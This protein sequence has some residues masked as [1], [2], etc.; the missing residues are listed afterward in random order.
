MNPVPDRRRLRAGRLASVSQPTSTTTTRAARETSGRSRENRRAFD[1]LG[2]PAADARR[3]VPAGSST[4]I[5]GADVSFPVL[6]APWAYQ[7]LAHPDGERATARARGEG[8]H[9]HGRLLDGGGRSSRRSRARA[10]RSSGGSSTCSR[11]AGGAPRCS[12]GCTRR[13]TRRSASRWT[14]RSAGSV[15]ATRGAASTCRSARQGRPR[16]RAQHLLGRPRRWI[17]E[18][19][20][21]PLLVKGIMTAEDARIAVDQ[22]AD[23]I[24]VS[25]HGGRQLDRGRRRGHGVARGGGGR[26][27][28]DPGPGGRRV[29]PGDRR[30]QGARPRRR[31]RPGGPAGL[32]GPR[33]RGR[34]RRR[35]GA[36]DPADR[37]REHDGARRGARDRGHQG[38]V[39]RSTLTAVSPGLGRIEAVP[40]IDLHTHSNRS[41]GTF[42]PA[43]VVRTAAEMGLDVVALDG[44]RHDRRAGRGARD[45]ASS[46]ASRSSPVSSSRRSSS[47]RASTS[48]ATGS[49]SRTRPSRRELHACGDDRFRRG[50]LIVEKLQDL[51]FDISFERVLADRG[52]GEYRPPARGAGDGRG[53]DRRGPRRRPSTVASRTAGPRTCRSTR[54]TPST[55]L[56]L[57]R[58]AGGLCVLAHPGM[59]GGQT[60]VPDDTDRARW[61]RPGWS[62][63]RSTTRITRPSSA[64]HHRALADRLGLLATGGSDCHGT[65]YDPIRMGGRVLRP[66]GGVRSAQGLS[67]GRVPRRAGHDEGAAGAAPSRRSSCRS[68]GPTP[69]PPGCTT[70]FTVRVYGACCWTSSVRSRTSPPPRR[71][72]PPSRSRPTAPRP[73][74]CRRSPRRA[75][76]RWTCTTSPASSNATI[77]TTNRLDVGSG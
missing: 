54:S 5:L 60:S 11:I 8:R 35:R 69:P 44:P 77:W 23:G 68:A 1:R 57:I 20:P 7:G 22:G 27:R 38:R 56:G 19:A 50:E 9:D 32:L 16:L 6:V 61:P 15:I 17:R 67:P 45:A 10:R 64:K 28:P 76:A 30:V 52:G 18:H 43:E 3:G 75:R 74:G 72:C 26:R 49:T 40:G 14:S 66:A 62:A 33:C 37:V 59:W 36:V 41:D 12:A 51:G 24:V 48:S 25:N 4:A 71:W 70:L 13:A 53:G 55:P 65:R 31:G 42:T 34:G 73:R 21:V 58:R 29:P 39:R 63:S 47:V 2:H 46:S